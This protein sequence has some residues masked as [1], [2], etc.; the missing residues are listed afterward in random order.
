M[1]T[2]IRVSEEV[3]TQTVSKP[4]VG[5][6]S[7]LVAGALRAAAFEGIQMTRDI[8]SVHADM[9]TGKCDKNE[10][11]TATEKRLITGVS[12]VGGQTVGTAIGQVLIPVPLEGDAIGAMVGGITGKY[13]GNIQANRRL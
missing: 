12:N 4:A 10:F 13:L 8:Y 1:K 9:K 11:T 7:R 2:G 5:L 6:A 3:A